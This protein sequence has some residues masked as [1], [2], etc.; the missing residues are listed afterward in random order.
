MA[1][2]R[3]GRPVNGWVVVDKP[4]GITS[5]RVVN[6]VRRVF[7]AAKAGHAGTLDP[8]ATGVLPIALGEATKTVPYIMGRRKS[9]RFEIRWG[10]ERDTDD[11]EG[12]VTRTS[13]VRP[14]RTAVEQAARRVPR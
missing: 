12:T 3:R 1:R 7:D 2:S 13:R 14:D 9:Y 10:E 6:T 4:A 11:C 5:T 8:F